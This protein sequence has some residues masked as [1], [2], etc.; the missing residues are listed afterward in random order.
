MKIL[1]TSLFILSLVSCTPQQVKTVE[2]AI[3][4]EEKVFNQIIY[5]ESGL[6]VGTT[7][8]PDPTP[9]PTPNVKLSKF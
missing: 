2:D 8:V 5:D 3:E 6:P 7:S 9:V 1:L 4:G